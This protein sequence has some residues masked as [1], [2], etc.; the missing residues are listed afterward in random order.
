LTGKGSDGVAVGFCAGHYGGPAGETFMKSYS[1]T[2]KKGLN[3]P[4]GSFETGDQN[5]P[6][7]FADVSTASTSK[8]IEQLLGPADKKCTF[9]VNLHV[10]PKHFDGNTLIR[11]YEAHDVASFALE[12]KGN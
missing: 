8:T 9:A 6:D 5:H 12:K 1:L 11:D 10:Y 7:P 4:S 3:G 2:W